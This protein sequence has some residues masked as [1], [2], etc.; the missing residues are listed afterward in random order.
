MISLCKI[1]SNIF[2]IGLD[3]DACNPSVCG[4]AFEIKHLENSDKV[5]KGIASDSKGRLYALFDKTPCVRIYD[6]DF[7]F[8]TDLVIT[9]DHDLKDIK[10]DKK[11]RIIVA[12]KDKFLIHDGK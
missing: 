5:F 7:K 10:V 11:G 2:G 1:R 6:Q 3:N 4:T 8:F 12:C 9:G